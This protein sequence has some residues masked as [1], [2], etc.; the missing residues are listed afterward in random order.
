MK[1]VFSENDN[2]LIKGDKIYIFK[3]NEWRIK[4][5]G[6]IEVIHEDLRN[7]LEDFQNKEI[8]NINN[9]DK[10][11]DLLV[12]NS[13]RFVNII[14]NRLRNDNEKLLINENLIENKIN[15]DT[16]LKIIQNNKQD[17]LNFVFRKSDSK[18]DD[19]D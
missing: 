6:D 11:A 2:E 12:N 1:E 10:N 19:S 3:N 4:S 16:L 15:K 13:I 5:E 18:F 8:I 7:L 17:I 9:K 14:N